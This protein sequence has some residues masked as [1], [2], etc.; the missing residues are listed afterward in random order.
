MHRPTPALTLFL[1]LLAAALAGCDGAATMVR[2]GA[3]TVLSGDTCV[4]APMGPAPLSDGG[5]ADAGPSGGRD[6]GPPAE[7][8]A[9]NGGWT[10]TGPGGPPVGEGCDEASGECAA[11]EAE[12]RTLLANHPLRGCSAP[13]PLDAGAQ[14]VADRHAAHQA[15]IDMLTSESPAGDLFQQLRAEGTTFGYGGALFSATRDGAAD[16]MTRWGDSS[17]TA[18]QLAP[19]WTMAGVA[20][21]TSATGAS[22]V[23]V[24]LAR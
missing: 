23:S 24:I 10:T 22:Y 6:A 13:M 9:G 14:A 7:R 2:C 11:W 3:G 19:C 8:D 21:A 5:S 20:V 12:L 17:N 4:P 18:A 1:W 16:V 15:S